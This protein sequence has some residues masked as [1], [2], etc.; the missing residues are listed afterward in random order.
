MMHDVVDKAHLV[1][2]DEAFQAAMHLAIKTEAMKIKTCV[3][4]QKSFKARCKTQLTCS[5][6]CSR[7][8]RSARR[9]KAMKPRICPYCGGEFAITPRQFHKIY[10]CNNCR[11][12]HYY[13]T[14]ADFRAK[15]KVYNKAY[16][17]KHRKRLYEQ[18]KQRLQTNENYKKYKKTYRIKN[19]D[20]I[21]A[22]QRAR[23]WRNRFTDKDTNCTPYRLK[24]RKV[25]RDR[26]NARQRARYWRDK[27]NSL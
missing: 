4:C 19:R 25:N 13:E 5:R 15:H 3:V 11:C 7:R 16:K 27:E 2:M 22:R 8:I 24:Y 21:N 26:I 17:A 10:C 14:N 23:Y 9:Q 12:K 18:F 1:K 6:Y 20:I